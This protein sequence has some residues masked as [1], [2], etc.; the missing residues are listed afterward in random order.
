MLS[1]IASVF[2]LAGRLS[3]TFMTSKLKKKNYR[4]VILQNVHYCGFVL[5]FLIRYR[6]LTFGI[7]IQKLFFFFILSYHMV[8]DFS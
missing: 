6:S 7:N 1:T 3:L 8:H 5:D 2:V 4:Q